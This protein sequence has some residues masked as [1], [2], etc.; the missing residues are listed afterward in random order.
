[1]SCSSGFCRRPWPARWR[2][3]WAISRN[4]GLRAY[5]ERASTRRT[6]WRGGVWWLAGK[7][8]DRSRTALVTDAEWAGPDTATLRNYARVAK[9]FE[10]SRAR[11]SFPIRHLDA[12]CSLPLDQAER[13]LET[14]RENG[15]KSY[16][17]RAEAARMRSAHLVVKR[18]PTFSLEDLI[19][20]GRRFRTIYADPPWAPEHP[21]IQHRLKRHYNS[22]A[23]ADICAL[24]IREL[25]AP[26]AHL[27]LWV[28]MSHLLSGFEVLEAWGFAYSGAGAVWIKPGRLGAGNFWRESHEM[29]L[30]GVNPKSQRF[31]DRGL[32]SWVEAPRSD[33]HS[34]KPSAVRQMTERA[35]PPPRLELFGRHEPLADWTVWG[36][37]LI[38][39]PALDAAD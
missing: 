20:E 2:R 29:L 36:N 22:L 31:A 21:I 9:K 24:P 26:E 35:S 6:R 5:G 33:I 11:D 19:A 30:L 28:P 37:Q 8:W 23:L 16:D 15:W 7:K 12:V 4:G 18:D 39:R 17:L 13:L 34:E 27:H 3:E 14:G 32:R 1:M 10:T 25:A 38:Q